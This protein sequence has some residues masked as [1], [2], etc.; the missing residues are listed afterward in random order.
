MCVC[1]YVHVQVGTYS[2]VAS[3]S[4]TCTRC[5]VGQTTKGVGARSKTACACDAKQGFMQVSAGLCR[6]AS[7][8][9]K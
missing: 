4:T 8:L 6:D 7:L 5:S 1:M 3:A 9:V 2:A